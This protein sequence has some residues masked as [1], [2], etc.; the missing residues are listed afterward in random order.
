MPRFDS[1]SSSPYE[2]RRILR[3]RLARALRP[4]HDYIDRRRS[5][6][7]LSDVDVLELLARAQIEHSDDEGGVREGYEAHRAAHPELPSFDDLLR[8]GWFGVAW[9][10]V[11]VPLGSTMGWRKPDEA[12]SAGLEVVRKAARKGTRLSFGELSDLSEPA[13]RWAA[14]KTKASDEL[15]GISPPSPDW[16]AARLWERRPAGDDRLA[17]RWWVDRWRFLGEP[18]GAPS[19]WWARPDATAWRRAAMAVLEAEPGL[20][21]WEREKKL[22][23]TLFARDDARPASNP[24]PSTSL[25]R[26]L[27]LNDRPFD[28]STR[29]LE[30]GGDTFAL[31][32]LLCDDLVQSDERLDDPSAS[33]L[34]ELVVARPTLLVRLTMRVRQDPTL[35]ADL[36]LHPAT[37]A[38][39]CL[40][41]AEWN[42]QPVGAWDRTIQSA[43]FVVSRERAFA[44][45][46]AIVCHHVRARS[47]VTGELA[48]FLTWVQSQVR[49]DAY[50]LGPHLPRI[51]LPMMD[52]VHAELQG[53]P[54]TNL[55]ELLAELSI[56]DS[57]GLGRPR[58]T[59]AI[60]LA[61]CASLAEQVD[62]DAAVAA[63]A[64]SLQTGDHRFSGTL[65]VAQA[66][67]LATIAMRSTRRT[68]FLRAID[69][70]AR[71]QAIAADENAYA[72]RDTIAHALRRHIRVLSRAVVGWEGSPPDA[73]ANALSDAIKA[74]SRDQS[75]PP[76]V[77]AFQAMHETTLSGAATDPPLA[78]EIADAC[79]RL[80]EEAR[81][82]MLGAL[83]Q[84]DEPL[85]IAQLLV[86]VPMSMREPMRTRLA[87][88]S[89]SKAARIHSLD[90]LRGRIDQLLDAGEVDAAATYLAIERKARTLGP[91]PGREVA[92]LAWDARLALLKQDFA[93]IAKLAIPDGL[94][95]VEAESARDTLSFYKG[96]AQLQD[97]NGSTV[98]AEAVFEELAK[99][100]PDQP[101]YALNLFASRVTALLGQD[102]F[103][104][105]A[106]KDVPR[107]R[108]VLH[109]A[110]VSLH[111]ALG[112][113][114]DDR[115][116]HRI[117][118]A[119]LL[120][121]IGQPKEAYET[122]E[123]VD[124]LARADRVAAY[125]A[126]ALERL[127]RREEAQAALTESEAAYGDSEALQE[128]RKHVDDGTPSRLPV[129]RA[130]TFDRVPAVRDALD[131]LKQLDPSQQARAVRSES[132]AALLTQQVRGAAAS[133]TAL[134]PNLRHV[135]VDEDDVTGFLYQALQSRV[136][137]LG[138]SV[139]DQSRGG[140]SARGNPGARDLVLR[141]DGCVISVLEAVVCRATPSAATPNNVLVSHFQKLFGYDQCPVLFYVAY[142]YAGQPGVVLDALRKMARSRAPEGFTYSRIE[143]IPRDDAR[144]VALEA[145]YRVD[146]EAREVKVVFV[147]LD[148]RQERQRNAAAQAGATAGTKAPTK[149]PAKASR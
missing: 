129:A 117:N 20:L 85:V 35:L 74:G 44:D 134:V 94:S 66:G 92:R 18:A 135:E 62:A 36:L 77:S 104:R 136:L 64:S 8:E 113:T 68:L 112:V 116:V 37:S 120:L 107:A 19:R 63:Y 82:R 145:S 25:D 60:D 9:S 13:Q 148:M 115:V 138:W 2:T 137:Y 47:D 5:A 53:L 58:F 132:L 59:A 28:H 14:Q 87:K 141:K 22:V 16:V 75:T 45:A 143:E 6:N 114:D 90:E 95:A 55:E 88:L 3:D 91:V 96:L 119:V 54:R 97:P 78:Y 51:T 61:N 108:E 102:T 100:R 69:V 124:G 50:T 56:Q 43:E 67:T 147:V 81:H 30:S 80:T 128:A 86:R 144:P 76:K 99:R 71:V 17:L 42:D 27:W 131:D 4:T 123:G 46:M 65:S 73:L 89:P 84:I 32:R 1:L 110:D 41:I 72:A 105:L 118:R 140:Y 10:R 126:V 109:A 93:A 49:A 26:F 127:G 98:E 103:K 24:L 101:S 21:G 48:A 7:V 79:G 12:T 38:L 29:A 23:D 121:A 57:G 149:R 111:R 130:Q 33:S 11:T 40:M 34:L 39:A 83:K 52:L 31:L 122:L 142:S 106:A 146:G 139:A 133:V 125:R 70:P 15:R